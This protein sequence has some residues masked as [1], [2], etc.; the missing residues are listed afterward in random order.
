MRSC[1]GLN[2]KCIVVP[3]RWWW[4]AVAI[5]FSIVVFLIASTHLVLITCL[6]YFIV[7]RSGGTLLAQGQEQLVPSTMENLLL[8]TVKLCDATDVDRNYCFQVPAPHIYFLSHFQLGTYG[9]NR[10]NW[11]SNRSLKCQSSPRPSTQ[12]GVSTERGW[13]GK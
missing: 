11:A 3:N 5:M 13:W 2:N 8:C 9:S 12:A 10:E 7:D 1:C 4:D 6:Q